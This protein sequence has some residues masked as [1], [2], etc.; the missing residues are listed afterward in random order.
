MSE[1]RKIEFKKETNID[2]ELGELIK[3]L[4]EGWPSDKKKIPSYLS[5]Y[6]KCRN[7]LSVTQG[8]VFLGLKVVVPKNLRKKV[9][10]L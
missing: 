1:E 8:L 7:E 6:W 4:E 2:K 5:V 9:L 10:M 3:Y